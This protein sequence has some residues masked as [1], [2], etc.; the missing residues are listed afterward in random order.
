MSKS[1]II[2]I[3]IVVLFQIFGANAQ[4]LV[5]LD[6]AI[7]IALEKNHSIKISKNDITIAENK[8]TLGNAGL[9]PDLDIN[10]S[11]NV[12]SLDT[13]VDFTGSLPSEEKAGANSNSVFA[14]LDLSYT[15]FDGFKNKYKLQSL[16]VT[17][18]EKQLSYSAQIEKTIIDVINAYYNLINVQANLANDKETYNYSVNRYNDVANEVKYGQNTELEL[19]TSKGYINTDSSRVL[20]TQLKFQ[21]AVL[22]L[23]NVL[24]MDTLSGTEIFDNS[25]N[26][27]K[28]M[29]K[30]ELF[31]KM[32]TNNIDIQIANSSLL[33]SEIDV[34]SNKYFYMPKIALNAS[35]GYG[36][37]EY[38]VG[39]MLL[40]KTIGPSVG[41]TIKRNVFAGDRKRKDLENAR[42]AYS[43][44]QI[45]LEETKLFLNADFEK[46]W[47]NYQ[48]Y[49]TLIPI[50]QNNV[51][52]A[53]QR[54]KKTQ[55]QYKLGQSSNLEFRDAQINLKK[56]N[57]TLNEAKINAKL[58]EW[59]LLRMAG[60]ISK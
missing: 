45:S 14:S 50:E 5:T 51:V 39:A 33:K 52:I 36:N 12:S 20:N 59:E 56:T 37:Q 49:L 17:S 43:S 13:K 60:L 32:F 21:K 24:G 3:L 19:L 44:Q 48:Y 1:K 38:E 6:A 47:L 9:L 28:N 2:I 29:A 22:D 15:L 40:N 30:E 10:I 57:S 27:T 53:E 34:K 7:A 26:L 11:G 18:L 54:F 16:R 25:I 58:A 35:Y 31:E 42:I 23:N 41:L 46:A 8:A 4:Q 55:S